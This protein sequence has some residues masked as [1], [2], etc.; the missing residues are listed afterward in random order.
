VLFP[1]GFCLTTT[2]SADFSPRR[3]GVVALSGASEISP[4]KDID[5]PRTPPDL[6][7]LTLGHLRLAVRSPLVPV[8]VALYPFPVRRPA[9]SFHASFRQSLTVLPLRFT[10]FPVAWY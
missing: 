5:L 1:A 3:P 8:G 7:R 10:S 4:G 6:R 2:A 9:G